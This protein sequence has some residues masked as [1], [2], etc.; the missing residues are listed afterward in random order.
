M[1][2]IIVST[3]S[4]SEVAESVVFTI[5]V[6]LTAD[7]STDLLRMSSVLH[8]RGVD[9]IEAHLSRPTAGCRTFTATFES[10]S[11]P[12][13]VNVARIVRARVGVRSVRIM[14]MAEDSQQQ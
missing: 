10:R 14:R 4:P 5:R 12:H 7:L 13:A 8:R 3:T 2:L 1:R 6:D 9:V 11:E